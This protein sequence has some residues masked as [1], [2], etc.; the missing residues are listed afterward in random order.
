MDEHASGDWAGGDGDARVRINAKEVIQQ[1]GGEDGIAQAVGGDE[2]DFHT[3]HGIALLWIGWKGGLG[4]GASV[5]AG[6]RLTG[7]G[8]IEIDYELITVGAK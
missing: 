1:P 5:V 3:G 6:W 8:P 4:K 2:E 7:L